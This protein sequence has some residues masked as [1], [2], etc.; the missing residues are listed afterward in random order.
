MTSHG[1][2][3]VSSSRVPVL[4]G[5][6]TGRD[7][8]GEGCSFGGKTTFALGR[9]SSRWLKGGRGKWNGSRRIRHRRREGREQDAEP[10]RA[11]GGTGVEQSRAYGVERGKCSGGEGRVRWVGWDYHRTGRVGLPPPPRSAARRCCSDARAECP[12]ILDAFISPEYPAESPEMPFSPYTSH[13]IV[14]YVS[15]KVECIT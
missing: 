14:Y 13:V 12:E 5:S 11:A 10:G 1:G 2:S 6:S 9:Q 15:A 8:P 4:W 3:R 7:R